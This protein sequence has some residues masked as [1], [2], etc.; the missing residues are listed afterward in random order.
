MVVVLLLL[1]EWRVEMN[2]IELWIYLRLAVGA[3]LVCSALVQI[4]DFCGVSVTHAQ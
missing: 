2:R 4:A 3:L 1:L